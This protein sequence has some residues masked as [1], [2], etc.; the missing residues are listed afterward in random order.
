MKKSTIGALL[1]LLLGA[2]AVVGWK[3]LKP[4]VFEWS[5]QRT[6]DATG[7]EATLRFGGDNYLGYW[8]LTSPE[9]RK[10]AARRGLAIQFE[11]DGGA[12]AERLAKFAGGEYDAIVLPVNSYLQHGAAVSFPGVIVAAV[13]E[14]RGADG[15]VGFADALPSGKIGDLNDAEL[16]IVYTSASPSEFFLDLTIADFDLDELEGADRWRRETAS[17]SDVYKRAKSSDGDV[18]VLW[19]P[20]LSRALSLPGM[21][22]IWGSDRFSGYIVDVFVFRRELLDNKRETI[23]DFLSLYFRV[24]QGYANNRDKMLK[25]MRQSEDLEEEALREILNKIEWF[26]LEENRRLQFGIS[27]QPGEQV[28]E[29]IINTIISCT[30][31]MLR[32]KR[33]T[34]DPLEGNP[35]LITNSSVLEELVESSNVAA[36]GETGR[37][38]VTFEALDEDG[39]RRLGEIGTFRLEPITFQSWNNQPADVGKESIDKIAQLLTHNYPDYRVIIRGHT[40]PGGDEEANA[41]LSLERA[42][43]VLQ[44]LKAV[45]DVDSDRMWAEGLGSREPPR[46]KPGE[47][48]RA[49]QYR[50]SRVEFKAVEANPL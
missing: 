46:R 24:L 26:D 42:Q 31:V 15:M 41:A 33:L 17:S 14:S 48:P 3:Y 28:E 25:E 4:L 2:A 11:D 1:L 47:S 12:Y 19:E 9:M 8:F 37:R 38:E 20:D 5:Q 23:R 13:A 49:Y 50:L 7:A 18:F 16:E 32:M 22:Y 35:F 44:Y 30:D 21:T 29:G 39:W 40:A 36:V 45:H 34:S 43:A 27:R 6:S 10:Q